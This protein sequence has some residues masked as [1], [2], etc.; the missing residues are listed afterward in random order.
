MCR[1]TP[2]RVRILWD[3]V[4]TE[5]SISESPTLRIRGEWGY[6]LGVKNYFFIS[7]SSLSTLR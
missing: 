1:I 5:P 2:E 6:A 3:A 4:G 7:F